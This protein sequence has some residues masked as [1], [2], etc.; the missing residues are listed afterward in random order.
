MIALWMREIFNFF[1]FGK[2]K[3]EKTKYRSFQKILILEYSYL[4]FFMNFWRMLNLSSNKGSRSCI[5]L[6]IRKGDNKKK[7]FSCPQS[8]GGGY[9]LYVTIISV[10]ISLQN[11]DLS[12]SCVRPFWSIFFCKHVR[13]SLSHSWLCQIIN[14]QQIFQVVWFDSNLKKLELYIHFWTLFFLRF[15]YDLRK[16]TKI[17]SLWRNV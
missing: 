4:Q 7:Y 17:T 1:N 9:P 6:L 2:E 14:K 5:N 8:G 15:T 12:K 16:S 3:K 11:C 10:H 13:H